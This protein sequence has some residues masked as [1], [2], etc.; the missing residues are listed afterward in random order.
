MHLRPTCI[1]F[2]IAKVF[3]DGRI[4]IV[5][6]LSARRWSAFLSHLQVPSP[7]LAAARWYDSLEL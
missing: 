2:V 3:V 1:G 6:Y 7:A 4:V 5:F